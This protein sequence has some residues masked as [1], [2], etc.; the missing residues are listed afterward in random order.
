[1]SAT[2]IDAAFTDGEGF[3][4]PGL[5]KG[6]EN[7]GKDELEDLPAGGGMG[8]TEGE[9]AGID[10]FAGSEG[11]AV[12]LVGVVA[13]ENEGGFGGADLFVES[14]GDGECGEAAD[15]ACGGE[16][17]GGPFA[18]AVEPLMQFAA[19]DKTGIDAEGGIV[20]EGASV[21]FPEIDGGDLSA[22]DDG[23]RLFELS[24]DAEVFGKMVEGAEGEDAERSF[25]S[26]EYSGGGA[27]GAIASSD[28]DGADV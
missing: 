15:D 3:E 28:D 26:G 13:D 24:G 5:I 14:D 27:E 2:G 23:N 8:E 25:G 18:H 21:D 11:E 9:F 4:I 6:A 7:G 17:H 16:E 22:G 20:D 12:Q 19:D 10:S 1:M